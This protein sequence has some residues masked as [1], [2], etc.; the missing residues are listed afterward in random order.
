MDVANRDMFQAEA[1]LKRFSKIKPL[2][3]NGVFDEAFLHH[4][5]AAVSGKR[6][7]HRVGRFAI[8]LIFIS[9]IYTIAEALILTN[10]AETVW[11][12]YLFAALAVVGIALQAFIIFT[13]QKDKWLVNR[14]A[15]ERLRS[16]KFQSFH[17]GDNAEDE[18]QLKELVQAF[19][20]R[21]LSRL[22][23]DLNTGLSLLD[24]FSPAKALETPT[25]SKAK[26]ADPVIAQQARDAY[27]ELRVRYQINFASS[28]VGRLKQKVRAV[29]SVQ[30]VT[31]FTAVGMAFLS[32]GLKIFD[33]NHFIPTAYVDFFA[34]TLFVSG[35]TKTITDNALLQEQSQS[36]Y[37]AYITNLEHAFL[38]ETNRKAT[39]DELVDRVERISL[40][41]LDHFCQDALLVS[42][43]F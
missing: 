23:N 37:E 19:S 14:F 1:T 39:L 10:A 33:A 38:M 26:D 6:L 36:R 25:H 12:N 29:T 18:A 16:L 2:L 28:E 15:C 13:K 4:E 3:Q 27:E 31:Y 5:R 17:L 30:D 32:L 41:E 22:E 9:A 8:F 35:A 20:E 42:Y 43:R 11:L 21:H 34:I 7:Y 24:R 40:N